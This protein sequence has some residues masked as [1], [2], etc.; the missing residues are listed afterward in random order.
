MLV[1]LKLIYICIL[2][3]MYPSDRPVVPLIVL[4]TD[5]FAIP[6]VPF[7]LFLLRLRHY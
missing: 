1:D 3:F 5:I 2:L 4:E 6:V 7:N